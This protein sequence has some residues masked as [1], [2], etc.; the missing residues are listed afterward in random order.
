MELSGIEIDKMELT[1][2]RT[3]TPPMHISSNSAKCFLEDQIISLNI[4]WKFVSVLNHVI[5][6]FT[7]IKIYLYH[8]SSTKRIKFSSLK[9]LFMWNMLCLITFLL[10]VCMKAFNWTNRVLLETATFNQDIYVFAS[11]KTL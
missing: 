8:L 9:A 11:I 6:H 2:C 7:Q 4:P 1:T 3:A 10:P 5:S